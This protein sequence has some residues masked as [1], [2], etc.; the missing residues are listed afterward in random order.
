[1]ASEIETAIAAD[2][3]IGPNTPEAPVAVELETEEAWLVRA[4]LRQVVSANR[5]RR[6]FGIAKGILQ[7]LGQAEIAAVERTL[8]NSNL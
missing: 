5:G 8:R 4:L 3:T 6:S 2:T 7:K 1:M